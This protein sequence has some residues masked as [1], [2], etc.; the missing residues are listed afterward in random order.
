[1]I[2]SLSIRGETT[3]LLKTKISLSLIALQSAFLL[4]VD[5]CLSA[6]MSFQDLIDRGSN[7]F[8]EG[9]LPEA[10]KTLEEAMNAA[11]KFAD[12]DPRRAVVLNQLGMVLFELG[13]YRKSHEF[14]KQ[15]LL[16]RDKELG[17]NH[18]NTAESMVRLASS[19]AALGDNEEAEKLLRKALNIMDNSKDCSPDEKIIATQHLSNVLDN[20]ELSK[21]SLFLQK[22]VVESRRKLPRDPELGTAYTSL[23][24]WYIKHN[25][26]SKAKK[27]FEEALQAD[28]AVLGSHHR[29]V[30][31]DLNN[32]AGVLSLQGKNEKALQML[33]QSLAIQKEST[34]VDSA[35]FKDCLEN[36]KK[37]L[38]KLGRQDEISK[39]EQEYKN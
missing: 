15:A 18:L 33:K 39:I 6:Q 27:A 36:I 7:E 19:S 5:A 13:E 26:I 35:P 32:V 17:T 38:K 31:R 23:G 1:M 14:F 24:N 28:Q 2:K 34:G 30:A 21:E 11:Q 9:K 29:S 3:M 37:I 16:I 25:D 20:L 12:K 22:Q 8:V 4:N 10:R